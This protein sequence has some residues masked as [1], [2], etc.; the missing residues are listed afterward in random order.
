MSY[1]MVWYQCLDQGGRGRGMK[2]VLQQAAMCCG[3]GVRG[4]L[5]KHV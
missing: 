2:Y 5:M 1:A 4:R 3:Q